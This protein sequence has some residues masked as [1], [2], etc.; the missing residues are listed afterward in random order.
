MFTCISQKRPHSSTSI[1]RPLAEFFRWFCFMLV[2]STARWIE[3]QVVE[4]FTFHN[5]LIILFNLILNLKI[6]TKIFDGRINLNFFV[7]FL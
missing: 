3:L 2:R 4:F 7:T 1:E 5:G 6:S